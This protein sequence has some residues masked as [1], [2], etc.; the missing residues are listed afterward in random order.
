MNRGRAVILHPSTPD[1]VRR[2]E[3]LHRSLASSGL[4]YVESVS[5]ASIVIEWQGVPKPARQRPARKSLLPSFV[6]VDRAMRARATCDPDEREYWDE[7]IRLAGERQGLRARRFPVAQKTGGPVETWGVPVGEHLAVNRD[8]ET[9][10][11]THVGTGRRAA[12]RSTFHEA[13]ALAREVAAWPEWATL[14]DPAQIT[15]EFRAKA[16]AAFGE[17]AA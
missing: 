8:G 4:A 2:R 13:V 6:T 11:V 17:V 7:M 15:P 14:R 12:V 10:A 9:W 5:E 3:F 1:S 16:R